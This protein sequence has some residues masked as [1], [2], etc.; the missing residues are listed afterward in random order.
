[1]AD[2]V[3]VQGEQLGENA[4]SCVVLHIANQLHHVAK[5]SHFL[6]VYI[7]MFSIAENIESRM[8]TTFERVEQGV[9]QLEKA[10]AYQVC[11]AN[12]V[13][14]VLVVLIVLFVVL[15]CS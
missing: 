2:L 10:E 9:E 4:V 1:M 8:Q 6:C 5:H 14:G 15:S 7:L 13:V 12:V 3:S 11:V